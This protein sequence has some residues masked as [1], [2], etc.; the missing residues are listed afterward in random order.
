MEAE[1]LVRRKC[2]KIPQSGMNTKRHLHDTCKK[3]LNLQSLIYLQTL[4]HVSSNLGIFLQSDLGIMLLY[5]ICNILS[6]IYSI[7][8]ESLA[9]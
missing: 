5:V 8:R 2:R 9:K 4:I 6:Y 3:T 7:L 1:S